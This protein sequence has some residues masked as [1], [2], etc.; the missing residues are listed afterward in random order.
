VEPFKTAMVMRFAREWPFVL[1]AAGL[2]AISVFNRK[3]F[4]RYM[5]PLGAAL[6]FPA[7]VRIFDWLRRRKECGRPCQTCAAECEVGAIR[8]TGEINA[9][10]CH[11]CLDC[12]VT[13]WSSEKCPPLIEK[14]RKREL[15]TRARAATS[16]DNKP[17]DTVL[18]PPPGATN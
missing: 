16:A 8:P 11:Y 2:L 3:F 18:V 12:Q 7:R 1:Y 17:V 10:E 4:C 13:Y 9:N 15:G 5:C 14:R 6:T